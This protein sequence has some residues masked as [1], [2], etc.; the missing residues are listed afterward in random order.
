MTEGALIVLQAR[1]GSQR[2]PGK[3]LAP[4]A[5]KPIVLR[6]VDRLRACDV[7]PVV[8]ATTTN[9]QDDELVDVAAA[10][11]V[12]VFRGPEDD[13][14]HRFVLAA[15][16]FGAD[17]VV[18]ATADNPAVDLEVTRRVVEV[19]LRTGVDCV[20]EQALPYG[21]TVE[22]VTTEALVHADHVADEATDREHVTP[23]IRRDRRFRSLEVLA[24]PSLRRPDVR[25]TVD[26][27]YDLTYMRSLM[28]LLGDPATEPTL[29]EVIA[30]ADSLRTRQAVE[31]R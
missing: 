22:A 3:A 4:I 27:L 1:M 10:Y 20:V 14:L 5:G 19:L 30:A 29:A 15:S 7:A 23:L 9:A 31:V 12:P 17:L 8:L 21:A 6:C 16:H 25:L 11:G 28:A 26:T 24:P 13:V 2:L 18:R